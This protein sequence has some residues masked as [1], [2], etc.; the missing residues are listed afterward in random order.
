MAGHSIWLTQGDNV[1]PKIGMSF[2]HKMPISPSFHTVGCIFVIY[3]W[4]H[5]S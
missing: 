1:N 2:M 5:N 3:G 4:R